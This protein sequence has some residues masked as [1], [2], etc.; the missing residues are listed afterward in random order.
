MDRTVALCGAYEQRTLEA[1]TQTFVLPCT[2]V[3]GFLGVG[4]TRRERERET[5][6]R[7]R[8]GGESPP[9]PAP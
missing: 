5:R 8:G 2:I 1:L 9:R 3:T 7:E 4:G 6:E